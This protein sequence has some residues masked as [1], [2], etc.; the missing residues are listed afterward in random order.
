M[1]NLINRL[2]KLEETAHAGHRFHI[3]DAV[4]GDPD[5]D[6]EFLRCSGITPRRGDRVIIW[7]DLMKNQ[8]LLVLYES[9]S[10]TPQ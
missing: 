5:V 6:E 3:V 7:R 4:V 9:F 8:S 10:G 1:K 2:S